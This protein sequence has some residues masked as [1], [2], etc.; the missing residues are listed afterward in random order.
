MLYEPRAEF[1]YQLCTWQLVAQ[2]VSSFADDATPTVSASAAAATAAAAHPR[3]LSRLRRIGIR[4]MVSSLE[5]LAPLR[6]RGLSERDASK[7]LAWPPTDS[8]RHYNYQL[9]FSRE[10]AEAQLFF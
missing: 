5:V 6:R 10:Q 4:T 8:F 2:W 7:A 1:Q 3:G 9:A